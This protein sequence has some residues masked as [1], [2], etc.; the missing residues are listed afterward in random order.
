MLIGGNS[1]GYDKEVGID[2]KFTH[3]IIFLF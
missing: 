1:I 2:K 3:R